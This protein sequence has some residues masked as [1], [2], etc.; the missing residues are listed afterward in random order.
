MINKGYLDMLP[1]AENRYRIALS[2]G[3]KVVFA[4]QLQTF[5]GDNDKLLGGSCDFTLTSKRMVIDNHAGVWTIHIADDIA[6]CRMVKGGILFL[7]YTAFNITL[8]EEMSYGLYGLEKTKGFSLH[9]SKEDT[10][11]FGEIVNNLFL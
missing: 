3:E 1:E 2:E 7:K 5:G 4:T 11:K 8:Y 9:F 10:V 6:D